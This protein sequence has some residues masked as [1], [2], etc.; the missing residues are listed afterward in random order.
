MDQHDSP[1][2]FC[3][4]LTVGQVKKVIPVASITDVQINQAN[5]GCCTCAPPDLF[6]S[7]LILC[8]FKF[9]GW[10]YPQLD[11]HTPSDPI[12]GNKDNIRRVAEVEFP[13]TSSYDLCH[14]AH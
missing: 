8:S 14:T 13:G 12:V 9:T 5:S 3:G 1:G 2:C 4:A 6:R 11:I 10:S 7:H